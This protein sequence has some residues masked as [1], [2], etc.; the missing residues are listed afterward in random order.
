MEDTS[1]AVSPELAQKLAELGSGSQPQYEKIQYRSQPPL[2]I[3]PGVSRLDPRIYRSNL[4]TR[5]FPGATRIVPTGASGCFTTNGILQQG[6]LGALS[7]EPFVRLTG[8]SRLIHRG[9]LNNFVPTLNYPSGFKY[10]FQQ[11]GY[12]YQVYSQ[13]PR[14]PS[15]PYLSCREWTL[16][17]NR[18]PTGGLGSSAQWFSKNDS[19]VNQGSANWQS[20]THILLGF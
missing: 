15:T 17:I 4:F 3:R 5:V 1:N 13:G 8:V 6:A 10:K 14:V 9:T 19:F 7:S 20:D 12:D 2:G 16:R 11:G 18:K